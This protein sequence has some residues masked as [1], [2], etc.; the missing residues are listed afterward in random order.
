MEQE[1]LLRETAKKLGYTRL[2]GN[3]LSA[4]AL[5]VEYAQSQGGITL[6]STGT[7][8]LSKHGTARAEAT[9][10]TFRSKAARSRRGS[11]KTPTA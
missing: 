4:L 5:G 1:D 8:V 2:G 7:F 6:G 3:V 9:L 10:Q 11:P